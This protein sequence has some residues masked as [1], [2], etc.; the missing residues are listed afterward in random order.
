M[1]IFIS[2]GSGCA[3][4]IKLENSLSVQECVEDPH[5]VHTL[6]VLVVH[7]HS[8]CTADASC[9]TF[10]KRGKQKYSV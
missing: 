4:E 2:A 7:A 10:G 8:S 6:P 1:V 5:I 3:L 9:V